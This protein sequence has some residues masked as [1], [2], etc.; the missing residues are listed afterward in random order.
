LEL[1]SAY[2]HAEA[3]SEV[4][5]FHL[6]AAL[7]AEEEGQAA[8]LAR[9]HGLD[10]SAWARLL[11]TPQPG[12]FLAPSSVVSALLDDARS[13][14]LQLTGSREVASDVLFLVLASHPEARNALQSHGLSHEALQREVESQRLPD[15]TLDSPPYFPDLTERFETARI[16]DA[17]AN[18]AREA[19][20]TIEDHARFVLE[21]AHLAGEAKA[22]RHELTQAL[23]ELGPEG[24]LHARDAV[25]DPGASLTAEGEYQRQSLTEVLKAAGKRMGEALRSLEEYGKVASPMLGERM[26]ALRY[27][28][29]TL[30]KAAHLMGQA[31]QRLAGVKLYVLLSAASCRASME[32]V[33]AEA[34]AGGAS[35]FQLREKSLTDRL[36]LARAREVRRWTRKAG[37]LLIINDRPDIARLAGADGVHL[38]QDDLSVREARRILGPDT[39]IGVSTHDLEQVGRAIQEGAS[40]IGLGP[41]FP[42]ATKAFDA[43]PGLR[44]LREA[45]QVTGI[46]A[47]AI[48]G[49]GPDNV[50]EVAR[51]GAQRVAVGH[52]ISSAESPRSVAR[53]LLSQLEE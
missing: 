8:T 4:G 40:Y 13:L 44:F 1:A 24:L 35:M 31:R 47:F 3:A 10:W 26:E 15:P 12:E 16:L 32:W 51:A 53:A 33:I 18:R 39:L 49:I 9:A 27:R 2:A 25:D 48:G 34:A 45:A 22:L 43:F 6:L 29:Y 11:P 52:A 38:G 21:D 37:A 28:A 14:A 23:R 41:T 46:P 30:E 7:L 17:A 50:R 19:L 20:R 36:L 5:P 42:S